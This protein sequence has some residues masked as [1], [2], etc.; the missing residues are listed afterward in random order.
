MVLHV[1]A[2]RWLFW[3]CSLYFPPENVC[4]YWLIVKGMTL[5]RA[6]IGLEIKMPFIIWQRKLPRQLL[7]FEIIT[8]ACLFLDLRQ[9]QCNYFYSGCMAK[10]YSQVTLNLLHKVAIAVSWVAFAYA[11][12]HSKD[13]QWEDLP[14]LHFLVK[15]GRRPCSRGL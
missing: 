13:I 11:L 8:S 5:W 2:C 10:L 14:C 9:L 4:L 1:T 3:F 12:S 15:Q 6:V 7:R